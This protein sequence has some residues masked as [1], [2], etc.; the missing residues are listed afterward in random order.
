MP[1]KDKPYKVYRGGRTKGPIKPIPRESPRRDPKP[2][3]DGDG[4][5][6]AY[7][8]TP[9]KRRRWGRKA[10][11]V[12]LLVI[13]LAIVWGTLGFLAFRSGVKDA[14]GRLDPEAKAALAPQEGSLLSNPTNVLLLG[15]D[16]G[17]KSRA[18]PGNGRSDSIMLIHTDPDDHRLALLSIPRD[19]RVTI[20]GRGEDRVNSAYSSGGP[21][22]AIRTVANLT[23]LPVNHVMIVDFKSFG[24]VV[25]AIGGVTIN[26]KKPILSRFEC[27]Y[28]AARCTSWR[29]YR[30]RKGDQEM[31]GRRALI[32][33][34]VRKNELNPGE[35]DF[36]R[37]E[38]QQ[39]VV[40]AISDK[41]VGFW[42]YLHMPLVG[43]DL[44]Q[45]LATD[46]SAWQIVQLG[47]VKFRAPSSKTLKCHLGGTPTSVGG[48]SVILGS[49][50]N[51]GVVSM[52]TGESAS[53]PPA[54]GNPFNPGC[55][56]DG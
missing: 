38:R 11:A 12:V 4:Y 20:P 51:A 53:Q 9:K 26:V 24:E 46:L 5:G 17:S 35:S 50:D 56:P 32:Y 8:P 42:G 33:A 48:A 6:G 37:A 44:V 49:E 13:V 39:Q 31:D 3:G 22:L 40:Q 15:A 55:R 2:A 10:V 30:F 54:P 27:P 29:G 16:V 7:V 25:D 14:N 41:T 34:R 52:V 28:T 19:L 47:W 18:G 21:A 1:S 45:P 23:G 43:D 36:S